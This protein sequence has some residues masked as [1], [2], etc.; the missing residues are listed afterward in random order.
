MNLNPKHA[1]FKK[2]K[3]YAKPD[4]QLYAQVLQ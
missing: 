1:S 2:A 4:E 3:E